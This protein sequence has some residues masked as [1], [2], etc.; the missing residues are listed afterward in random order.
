[1]IL[2]KILLQ[3]ILNKI[4]ENAILFITEENVLCCFCAYYLYKFLAPQWA[5]FFIIFLYILKST[6]ESSCA[7]KIFYKISPTE[8]QLLYFISHLCLTRFQT[9]NSIIQAKLSYQTVR[10]TTTTATYNRILSVDL[11]WHNLIS[12]NSNKVIKM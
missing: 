7:T 1:M 8:W 11:T 6:Y 10:S 4:A 12:S 9:G 3:F 2:S 5:K